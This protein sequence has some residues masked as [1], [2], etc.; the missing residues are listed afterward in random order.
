[1][2]G[3]E[4]PQPD[5]SLHGPAYVEGNLAYLPYGAAGMVVL[6][7]SDVARPKLVG[8]LGFTPPFLGFI[9]VHSVLPLK[10]RG[11]AVVNSEAIA[12]DCAEPLNHASLVDIKNPAKP[13]LLALF[14]LPTPP[15]GSRYRDFCDKGG[16][17][18]PHNQ[19]QLYHN[20]RV[21]RT[22]TLS[23]LTYFNAGLRVY[24]ISDARQ[25]RELGYFIP[26]DPVR[27]VGPMPKKTLVEQTEDVLVDSRG[28]I[29]VTNKQ[30]GLWVLQYT[31]PMPR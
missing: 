4:K 17:F 19:S 23:F 6:D 11:I 2:A 8:Q 13:V 20:P 15:P 10:G 7:I 9:G 22:E 31:G 29:Y 14:P 21:L 24:D 3:G 5:V 1:V 18:G 27:R 30:G 28:Y 12:E 16:R 26:P 25:V